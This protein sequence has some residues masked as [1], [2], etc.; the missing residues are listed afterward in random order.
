[1]NVVSIGASTDPA[2]GWAIVFATDDPSATGQ[3]GGVGVGLGVPY[4]RVGFAVEWRI[5]RGGYPNTAPDHI[6]VR[7]LDGSG[8]ARPVI[9]GADV[10]LALSLNYGPTASTIAQR[11]VV[12][13][14]PPNSVS[15]M[16][17]SIRVRLVPGGTPLFEVI[18]GAPSI[19]PGA[20]VRIG[21]TAG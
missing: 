13:Y 16:V 11:M 14:T 8:I 19:R 9:A 1:T 10:P 18:S 5:Y 7:P 15:G 21:I 12:E 20:N 17:P 3:V 2:D 4:N 6:Q